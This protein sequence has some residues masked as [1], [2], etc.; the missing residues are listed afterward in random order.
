MHPAGAS[1]WEGARGEGGEEAE[2]TATV[3]AGYGFETGGMDGDD[4]A[5]FSYRGGHEPDYHEPV[6]GAEQPEDV[7]RAAREGLYRSEAVYG[8]SWRE[9][10]DIRADNSL[11]AH[12]M[13]MRRALLVGAGARDPAKGHLKV[14]SSGRVEVQCPEG[15]SYVPAVQKVEAAQVKVAVDWKAKSRKPRKRLSWRSGALRGANRAAEI[16]GAR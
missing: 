1:V 12:P 8:N 2:A 4:D 16:A 14:D 15:T 11:H 9:R 10:S 7:S 3:T 13:L 5:G 6:Y